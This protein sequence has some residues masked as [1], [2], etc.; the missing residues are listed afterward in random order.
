MCGRYRLSRRKQAI[1]EY[2]EAAGEVEW[3]PRYNIAPSQ[4]IGV[5]RQDAAKPDRH[6]SLVR[7]GLVPYWAKDGSVGNKM[8]NARAETAA[9]K[10]AFSEPFR[11]R[12]CLV[13]ADGFYEWQRGTRIKQAFHFGMQDDSL[14]AFAGVWDRWRDATGQAVETCSILTTTP[15]S[16]LVDVHD[17]MPVI[18]SP[19]CYELWLDPGFRNTS[20]LAE[21]LRPLDARL[22]K[23]YPVGVRVNT[24]SNDDAQCA[25]AVTLLQAALPLG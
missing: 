23:R 15:N 1:E 14:F 24:V 18:L 5:I 13:P 6:F 16:L 9:D 20:V 17:R 25:A 12:R 10:A 8:I 11:R 7:W 21:V 2:F 4:M 3:E 22:M 19:E